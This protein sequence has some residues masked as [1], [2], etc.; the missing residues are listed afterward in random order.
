MTNKEIIDNIKSHLSN[1]KDVDVIYLQTEL[2]IYRSMKNEEVVYAIANMLFQ[3]MS[4][5]VKEKLDLRTH[6]VLNERRLEYET[7]IDLISNNEFDKAKEILIRLVSIY[8]K[9]TY[10]KE[11]N[12][13][14]F[15]QMIEYYIFCETVKNAK[16][17]H[18]RRYP[19]PLTY[20][21]YQLA[22]IYEKENNIDEAISSLYQA[23]EFN[24]RCQYIFGELMYL[25]DIKKDYDKLLEISLKSL[26][27]AYSKDQIAYAYMMIAKYYKNKDLDLYY[28]LNCVSNSFKENKTLEQGT[29]TLNES[30]DKLKENN[31][32][33][34]IS[35][36][37][38]NA[39]DEFVKYT[40]KINDVESV[41]YLLYIASDII[42]NEEYTNLSKEIE[43]ITLEK[44]MEKNNEE[45]N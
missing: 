22:T 43:K 33:Y 41:M 9:A 30:I 40:K 19:E 32:Q 27:Y 5:E 14:D 20:Y 26:K 8:Q 17:L 34:N 28:A 18:V 16:H 12:F 10:T 31:I 38:K 39:I 35:D 2:E 25:Y 4:P 37:V 7:V 3:Y 29:Y 21:M 24:P 42:E 11:Q 13:Y 36:V 45:T 6:E 15:D 44:L 23:L 1:D